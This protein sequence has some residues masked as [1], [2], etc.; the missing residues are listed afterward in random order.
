MTWWSWRFFTFYSFRN[1]VFFVWEITMK[2]PSAYAAL[3]SS[4]R[5]CFERKRLMQIACSSHVVR[6]LYNYQKFRWNDGCRGPLEAPCARCP[7][8]SI[9]GVWD[10]RV[11]APFVIRS[12][13]RAQP[14]PRKFWI[15]HKSKTIRDD[16]QFLGFERIC[17]FAW[18][19]I[20]DDIL[21]PNVRPRPCMV[22]LPYNGHSK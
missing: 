2:W 3:H 13:F 8:C 15:Y 21:R 18:A 19:K 20:F 4:H 10:T 5:P 12:P 9:E 22:K 11:G 7:T 16:V 14:P 1:F 6:C 17:H